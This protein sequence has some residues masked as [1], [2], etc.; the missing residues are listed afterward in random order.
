MKPGIGKPGAK[1]D[2]QTIG[3]RSRSL[4]ELRK[5]IE[6]LR[7]CRACPGMHPPSV[8]GQSVMSKVILIGQAPGIKEPVL[9]RPFA[10]TAGKNLFRWF[11]ECAGVDEP[12]FRTSVYMAAVCRCFPGKETRGGDRVPSQTEINNCSHWLEREF[13]I[14]K[15]MLVIPVGKLAIRRFLAVD[16]L[17]TIIGRRFAAK[18]NALEFDLIPLPHPSGASTWHRTEPGRT[19]LRQALALIASHPAWQTRTANDR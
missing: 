19:L 7:A 13:Q 11:D 18:W 4:S 12:Q 2:C 10:W 1:G 8:V 3:R 17:E 14:L 16:R 9:G 6:L 15:P 5:H